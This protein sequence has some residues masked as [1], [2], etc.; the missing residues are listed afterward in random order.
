MLVQL[1]V[2]HIITRTVIAVFGY[3]QLMPRCYCVSFS[4]RFPPRFNRIVKVIRSRIER[5]LLGGGYVMA[6][7]VPEAG[8]SH[9]TLLFI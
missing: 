4:M 3:A 6:S 8:Q 2:G 7:D 5:D 9:G 1:C